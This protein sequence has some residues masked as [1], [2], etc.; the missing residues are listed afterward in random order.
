MILI[1]RNLIRPVKTRTYI[2]ADIIHN[3]SHVIF[4]YIKLSDKK[5]TIAQLPAPELVNNSEWFYSDFLDALRKQ[6]ITDVIIKQD[7]SSLSAMTKYNTKGLV[8]L[9]FESNIIES[10]I[11]NNVKV[12]VETREKSN[13]ILDMI[14]SG[15][16][17]M[18][19]YLLFVK[20]ITGGGG[21]IGGGINS[22]SQSKAR[23]TEI[24]E[25]NVTFADIAGCDDGKN[26]VME[27]VDFLKSPEKYSVLG[28]KIPKGCLLVGSPGTGKTL[29]AKAIAGESGVPFFSCSAS[30][31]MEMFVGVG[32]S[33]IRDMF[34]K[35]KEKAPCII[36]ID[37]I[38]A[39]GKTRSSGGSFGGHDERDQTINQLLTE[40]DGFNGNTGV[41]ILASTNRP[42]ILDPALLR[43]GRFDRRVTINLPDYKG[44]VDILKIHCR[45]KPLSETLQLSDI[46][47]ITAGFSGADLENLSNE[48]AIYGVR[49]N[50]LKITLDH[51]NKALDKIVIGPERSNIL[52]SEEKKRIIAF[53]EA[54]HALVSLKINSEEKLRK[55][56]I[57]PRG[58]A[59]GVTYFEPSLE[60]VD[61]GLYSRRY[62][63]NKI[64]VSLGGRIAEE[65]MFGE[66][67][68]TTG[69]SND[70]Q[71][72]TD[73]ARKMVTDF[74]FT[75]SLG[76]SSWSQ[77]HNISPQIQNKIDDEILDILKVFYKKTT[78]IIINNDSSLRKIAL[79][80]L[81]K[82]TLTGTEVINLIKV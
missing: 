43:A 13:I 77:Q 16:I 24:P 50:S 60:N 38:D 53:H 28:A 64:M 17:M 49:D 18:S 73:I 45:N 15:V 21:N 79:A 33:R 67:N 25:T 74:G 40:M 8:E 27:I 66:G 52:I 11:S 68:T 26:E 48:A 22:F 58:R 10:L 4:D 3:N 7:L 70:F 81:E 14:V 6:E 42:E 32:A 46:A 65:L 9:P 20:L 19:I 59:A 35:A 29:L 54:G 2:N 78:N 75:N 55:V 34:K 41:I 76:P 5:I 12:K 36:F 51:F 23:F 69:A 30:E 80:L 82:E 37:E 61:S 47:K 72:A 62:L 31:F 71:N 56:T 63:E 1:K 44:R 39:I 57:I